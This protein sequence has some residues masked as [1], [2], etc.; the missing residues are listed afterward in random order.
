M[1]PGAGL[2]SHSFLGFKMFSL[3]ILLVQVLIFFVTSASA[4]PMPAFSDIGDLRIRDGGEITGP[5]IV[6]TTS[7]T[8][9]TQGPMLESCLVSMTPIILGNGDPAV[10]MVK[11][12]TLTLATP[13]P[14]ANTTDPAPAPPSPPIILSTS[15]TPPGSTTV[16]TSTPSPTVDPLVITTLTVNDPLTAVPT[17]TD[18]PAQTT[19]PAPNPATTATDS[20]AYQDPAATGSPAYQDPAATVAPDPPSTSS[21]Q[22]DPSASA[23]A[24]GSLETSSPASFASSGKKLSVLPIGLGVFA[25]ISVI[26]LVVVGLVTYER[27]KYR[28]MYRRRKLAEELDF[29]SRG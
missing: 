19:D 1:A 14:I 15:S 13:V 26:A 7:M 18:T 6:Q 21:I 9:T 3:R 28:K 8:N 11:N 16:L 5:V 17:G 23:V 29:S 4:L 24:A 12:C 2:H 10:E 22:L 25:G 20:P 27:T